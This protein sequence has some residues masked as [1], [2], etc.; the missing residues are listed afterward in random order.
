MNSLKLKF[1]FTT[2]PLSKFVLAVLVTVW[3]RPIVVLTHLLC[4]K[5]QLWQV[6]SV[7]VE[8]STFLIS[9]RGSRLT[10]RWLPQAFGLT[11][12]VPYSRQWT[13]TDLLPGTRSYPRLA[14]KFVLL[15][16]PRLV[17]PIR[18]MTLLGDSL[19]SVPCV[20]LQLPPS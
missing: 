9:R 7:N 20:F 18:P 13:P 4:R 11:L 16:F 3:C 5:T 10:N 17:L 8:T 15:C 2:P 19:A 12:L 14:E 6:P 1:A